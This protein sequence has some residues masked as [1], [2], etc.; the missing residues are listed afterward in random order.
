MKIA[1]IGSGAWA[2]A[3]ASVLAE[4]EDNEIVL[5]GKRKEEVDDINLNHKNAAYFPDGSGR[6]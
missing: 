5:Y 4:H 6:A 2:T 1:F 3:L